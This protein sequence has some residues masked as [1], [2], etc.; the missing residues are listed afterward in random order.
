MFHIEF[1]I[2]NQLKYFLTLNIYYLYFLLLKMNTELFWQHF[3]RLELLID[4]GLILIVMQNDVPD[5]LIM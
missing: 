3:N 4:V 5:S 2:E 1:Y